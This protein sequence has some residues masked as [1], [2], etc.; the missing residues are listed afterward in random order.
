MSAVVSAS[1]LSAD[2]LR[3]GEELERI[4]TAG[5]GHVHFDV[6]D[7]V[8]VN[9]ISF[10]LPMLSG[11]RRGTDM[12]ID[13]HL[14]ITDPE[15]YIPAFAKAGADMISFHTE[16]ADDPERLLALIRENGARAGLAVKPF[17]PLDRVLPFMDRADYILQ[18]TVEP[19]FGGQ[20]FITETLPRLCETKNTLKAMG[21]DIPV[22]VD[23]GING[24]TAAAA[25]EAGAG[26]LV[27]GSYLFGQKDMAAAVR[28]LTGEKD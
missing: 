20:S 27:A 10:G 9:N 14:M 25:R 17:T 21:R 4:K 18:M 5:C 2:V 1:L 16:A 23:G 26:I 19:G 22:Q 28:L 8:F 3:L 6:M 7:G 24:E 15:K 13:V 12:P 11:V